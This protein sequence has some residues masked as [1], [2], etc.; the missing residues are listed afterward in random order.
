MKQG[1]DKYQL[2]NGS[3]YM[4]RE[5]LLP[6]C[7]YLFEIQQNAQDSKSKNFSAGQHS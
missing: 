1:I 6:P 5:L 4:W 2:F 7:G 3:V